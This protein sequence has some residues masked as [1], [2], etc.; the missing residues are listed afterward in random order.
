M[1]VQLVIVQLRAHG[2]CSL[3]NEQI[4]RIELAWCQAH[5]TRTRTQN[6]AHSRDGRTASR[7]GLHR[8][9][10]NNRVVN[11]MQQQADGH[12]SQC[13]H[14]MV[15]SRFSLQKMVCA[16]QL[17]QNE[18]LQQAFSYSAVTHSLTH[19]AISQSA[20]TQ[21][22]S[23]QSVSQSPSHSAIS[24]SAVSQSLSQSL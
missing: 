20:V 9:P 16:K 3:Y 7:E 13:G 18:P 21:S 8:H 23:C 14:R 24:H 4:K 1:H 17:F 12:S 6:V 5:A 10:C 22:L 2:Y 11:Q 15:G 19:S